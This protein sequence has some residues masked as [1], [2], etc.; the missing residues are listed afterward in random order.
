MGERLI[1]DVKEI[2]VGKNGKVVLRCGDGDVQI[3]DLDYLVVVNNNSLSVI[4]TKQDNK[5]I[6]V[7]LVR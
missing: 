6:K 3:D 2:L 5:G 4:D 1:S 7:T